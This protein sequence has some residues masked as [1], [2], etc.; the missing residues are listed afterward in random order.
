MDFKVYNRSSNSES[1]PGLSVETEKKL[2]CLHILSPFCPPAVFS[3]QKVLSSSLGLWEKGSQ[4]T[5]VPY[6]ISLVV[7]NAENLNKLLLTEFIWSIKD[8][9]ETIITE[10]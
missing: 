9:N 4:V 3:L 6:L 5:K 8:T 7:R 10:E 2:S 1:N